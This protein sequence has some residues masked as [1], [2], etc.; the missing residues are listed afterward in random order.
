MKEIINKV[1]LD[2]RDNRT[3]YIN[4][5]KVEGVERFAID[6]KEGVTISFPAEINIR[7]S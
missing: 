3:V 2:T 6:I 4:G 7:S 5:V 1:E